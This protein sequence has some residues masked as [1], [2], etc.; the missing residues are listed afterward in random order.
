MRK[1]TAYIH[2]FMTQKVTDALRDENVHGVTVIK[3][4]GFGRRVSVEDGGDY[5]DKD[6][7]IGFA[8]KTK[9]E[10]ICRSEES[11]GIIEVIREAAH[12]G[13]HGDGK[14]FVSAMLDVMDIRT[15][16]KGEDVL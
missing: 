10:I 9:I 7:E 3:C 16:N 4:E 15:G 6:V 2:D 12:T 14:I 1:I 8:P 11:D 13:R 5:L